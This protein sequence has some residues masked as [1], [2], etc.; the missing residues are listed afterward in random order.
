M[1]IRIP[2]FAGDNR[3]QTA[4]TQ[5]LRKGLPIRFN[6]IIPETKQW[7]PRQVRGPHHRKMD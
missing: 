2:I 6:R 3:A 1:S 4:R 5:L 7:G